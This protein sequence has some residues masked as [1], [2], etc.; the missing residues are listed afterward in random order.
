MSS[1][2]KPSH[3]FI[4]HPNGME[5]NILTVT[6]TKPKHSTS[7]FSHITNDSKFC[8]KKI[9]ESVSNHTPDFVKQCPTI[10]KNYYQVKNWKILIGIVYKVVTNEIEIKE[11]EKAKNL[12]RKNECGDDDSEKQQQQKKQKL[13]DV[14]FEFVFSNPLVFNCGK[15]TATIKN[16]TGNK[17]IYDMYPQKR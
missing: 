6:D 15:V 7:I 11:I 5:K 13:N 16:D 8:L 12:K 14:K 3:I 1:D 9:S 17:S 4:S 2:T 10:G